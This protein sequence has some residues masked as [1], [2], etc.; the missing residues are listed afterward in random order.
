[1]DGDVVGMEGGAGTMKGVAEK[2]AGGGWC[3]TTRTPRRPS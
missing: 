2:M 3:P 1:M